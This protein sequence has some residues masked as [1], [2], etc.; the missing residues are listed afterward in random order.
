[1]LWKMAWRNLSRN[2][3]RSLITI[4][5]IALGVASVTLFGG[6]VSSA[7][8][9]LSRQAIHGEKLGHLTVAKQGYFEFGEV[10]QQDFI[11]SAEELTKIEGLLKEDP[12]VTL[13]SPRLSVRGLA[14]NGAISTIFIGDAVNRGDLA[15]IRADYGQRSGELDNDSEY[16]VAL[17]ENLA[18]A[19][20]LKKGDPG[21]VFGAT[22]DGQAN[23]VDFDVSDI[24]NTGNTATND[25]FI[26]MSMEL[27]RS[28]LDVEGAERLT[29]MLSDNGLTDTKRAALEAKLNAAGMGVEV[30]T[31]RELSSFFKQVKTLF[32]LIFSFIFAIVVIVALMSVINTMSMIVMER[33]REIGTLRALGMQR[34]RVM[35]LFSFEGFLLALVG[36]ALGLAILF[37]IGGLVNAADLSYVP[38]N[39]SNRVPL[40]VEFPTTMIVATAIAVIAASVLASMLPARKAARS[41]IATALTHA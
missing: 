26:L 1:M 15:T 34:G 17:A 5:A 40:R 18:S 22:I 19:L 30:K 24:Y 8:S 33:T 4:L 9:G 32:T 37:G 36:V 10:R 7:F 29:I 2:R 14:S 23:A 6:Y 12:S 11:F 28:L 25:K 27:A 13:V 39:S 31:W 21:V 35:R 20:D 38:P 16:G 3:R 41:E